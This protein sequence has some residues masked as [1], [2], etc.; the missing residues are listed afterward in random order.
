MFLYVFTIFNTK[1][2]LVQTCQSGKDDE[3]FGGDDDLNF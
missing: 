2:L 3:R 1:R